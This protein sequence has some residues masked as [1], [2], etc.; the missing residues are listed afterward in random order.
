RCR[1]DALF[2]P[3]DESEVVVVARQTFGVGE[4]EGE[5]DLRVIVHEIG[6]LL[7]DAYDQ[8]A[9]S[10]YIAAVADEWGGTECG[11]PKFV[12]D[13]CS[14][15][16]RDG[17]SALPESDDTVFVGKKT[18]LSGLNAKRVQQR[19]VYDGR[20]DP[21]GPIA[22]HEVGLPSSKCTDVGERA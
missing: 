7:H 16:R 9:P 10:V 4:A 1:C 6:A 15:R 17:D 8:K 13:D 5:P 3:P 21:E 12:R 11:L 20:A 2:Q 19:R 14:H 18:P 22:C